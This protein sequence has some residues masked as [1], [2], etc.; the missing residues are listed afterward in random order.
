VYGMPVD[1]LTYVT[2]R[3]NGVFDTLQ[4]TLA[5]KPLKLNAKIPGEEY[6]E[7]V[8][9]SYV[10]AE[11]IDDSDRV[12]PGYEREKCLLRGPLDDIAL[13]LRWEGKDSQELSGRKARVRFFM[14]ASYLYAVT[15]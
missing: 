4:F 12:F 8:E 2:S 1:R 9:Q 14:R 7:G 13:P 15:A 5:G 11:L 10:M 3:A 6:P